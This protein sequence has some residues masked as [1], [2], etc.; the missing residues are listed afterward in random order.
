MSNLEKYFDDMQ[1]AGCLPR[2][3]SA[4]SAASMKVGEKAR[5]MSG[6]G[7]EIECMGKS[8]RKRVLIRF[9]SWP[10]AAKPTSIERTRRIYAPND[11]RT[12]TGGHNE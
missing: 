10:A 5:L 4:R 12:S 2:T 6:T 7:P 8:G 9:T 11:Q 1:Q 3:C